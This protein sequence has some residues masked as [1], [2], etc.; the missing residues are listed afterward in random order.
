VNPVL[1][2]RGVQV[3][4]GSSLVL[5]GID[6]DVHPGEVVAIMGANGSGK[7]T[8]IRTLI[9]ALTP[10]AGSV[11]TPGPAAI[12]YVPQRIAASGGLPATAEEVVASGLLRPGRLSLPR[13][14]KGL[15][16]DALA[17]VDLADR[18]HAATT[19]LSGGQQQ[20]VLIARALVRQPHLLI[21]DEPVSGVDAP[22]QRQF[23]ATL[24]RLI[25][26][27]MTVVVVLHELGDLAPLITRAV[28]LRH[29]RVVHDGPPPAATGEHAHADH[30]HV[31]PHESPDQVSEIG[32]TGLHEPVTA[33]TDHTAPHRPPTGYAHDHA[34][35][36][37][38]AATSSAAADHDTSPASSSEEV[39]A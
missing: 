6:L 30:D 23:A 25:A 16:R 39:S 38:A 17:Q 10:T 36:H 2:V 22:S 12:G 24:A 31:H 13:G 33:L 28:V 4:L 20:R 34:G 19:H 5:R 11:R 1:E 26:D 9:G 15:V 37:S 7:S 32:F 27:G 29:G 21:L 3:R 14:W 35:D 18:V 8:L